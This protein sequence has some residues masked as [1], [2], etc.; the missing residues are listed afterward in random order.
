MYYLLH[1]VYSNT[2]TV[3]HKEKKF[4]CTSN[5]YLITNVQRRFDS[6]SVYITVWHKITSD[7][8]QK[9][10]HWPRNSCNL[11]ESSDNMCVDERKSIFERKV[12]KEKIFEPIVWDCF[13]QVTEA[14]E[15]AY[16]CIHTA[17]PCH[18][19]PSHRC[20]RTVRCVC[21]TYSWPL[22]RSNPCPPHTEKSS[23]TDHPGC[24]YL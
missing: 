18:S 19:I 2:S 17:D 21:H 7:S 10:I 23:V 3:S 16:L 20:S 15:H 12:D 8:D 14:G 4:T 11:I 9:F 24:S 6:G 5:Q 1:N 22:H 13:M